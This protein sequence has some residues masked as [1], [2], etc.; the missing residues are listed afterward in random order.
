MPYSLTVIESHISRVDLC[1]TIIILKGKPRL[2]RP[3]IRGILRICKAGGFEK[4][5]EGIINEEF[6]SIVAGLQAGLNLSYKKDERVAHWLWDNGITPELVSEL[7]EF[8]ENLARGGKL[9]VDER[10]ERYNDEIR[11]DP[12]EITLEQWC[13]KLVVNALGW[14]GW[15]PEIVL[16]ANINVIHMAME[17]K[18]DF[19]KKTNPFGSKD[20]P[21]EALSQ[22][23]PD[24]ERAAADIKRAFQRRMRMNNR[25]ASG[26]SEKA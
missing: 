7:V 16:K 18:I 26:W 1:E 8:L 12:Y 19:V 20:D 2:L 11:F 15:T 4:V 17:G 21:S 23:R 14:L 9:P 10:E 22:R 3:T 6:D 25:K 24:P 5:I 13:D